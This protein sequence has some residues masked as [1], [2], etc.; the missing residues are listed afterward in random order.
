MGEVQ[1]R[2]KCDYVFMLEEAQPLLDKARQPGT[3]FPLS[4]EWLQN[5]SYL[6]VTLVERKPVLLVGGR[7]ETK[8]RQAVLQVEIF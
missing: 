1:L 3:R 8:K 5:R 4:A 6:V 7:L 2:G